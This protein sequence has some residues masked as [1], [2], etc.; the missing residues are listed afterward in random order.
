MLHEMGIET[1]V[2]LTKLIDA[3][4]AAQDVLGRPLGAHVLRAGPVG[5]HR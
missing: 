4:R 5:W 2:D 1:G 3:S